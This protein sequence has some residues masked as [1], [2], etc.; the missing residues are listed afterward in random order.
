MKLMKSQHRNRMKSTTLTLLTTVKL[1]T[2]DV[3]EY[4]PDAA[5]KQWMTPKSRPFFMENRAATA[6]QA[7][8]EMADNTEGDLG[9]NDGD[10]CFSE[11]G[12]D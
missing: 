8:E 7:A 3:K 10:V 4:N 1:H 2:P 6:N 12:E 9:W 5:I 11:V